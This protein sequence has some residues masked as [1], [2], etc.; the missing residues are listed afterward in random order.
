M[1]KYM[2]MKVED[3]FNSYHPTKKEWFKVEVICIKST[4]I[5]IDN[6]GGKKVTMI[7]KGENRFLELTFN[8]FYTVKM[9]KKLEPY[10]DYEIQNLVYG[11][12][13]LE[14]F[15]LQNLNK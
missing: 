6:K 7:C 15:G 9:D 3:T 2:D 8:C 12:F 4:K 13:N 10:I 14:T 11:W 5:K 1:K